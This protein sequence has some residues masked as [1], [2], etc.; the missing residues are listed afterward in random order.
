[1]RI[2]E[3]VTDTGIGLIGGFVGTKVMEPV[4]MKLYEWEPEES[5]RREDAVRPGPPYQVAANKI[6]DRLDLDLSD[7][8]RQ[9]LGMAFHYGLGMA[10]GPVYT[11][12]ARRSGLNPV[13]AGLLTGAAMSIIADELMTPAMGASAPNRDYPLVTHLRG[14]VAHLAFGL[15]VAATAELLF[16]LRRM[17]SD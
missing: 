2:P 12:L 8:Q 15:G 17:A 13:A 9:R 11:L 4:S 14:F 16:R 5:R 3:A 1:M 10:W 6:A 7:S